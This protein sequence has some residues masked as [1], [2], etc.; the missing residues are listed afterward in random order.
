MKVSLRLTMSIILALT[1]A[2]LAQK[3]PK[4]A[5]GRANKGAGAAANRGAAGRSAF[6][7]SF[8]QIRWFDSNGN[9][10]IDEDEFKAGMGKMEKNAGKAMAVLKQAFD[11]DGDGK[12]SQA[13]LRKVREFVWALMG[14][15]PYDRNR[16]WVMSDEEWQGAWD[17]VGERCHQ[18][19]EFLLRRF[20][21]NG[22]EALGPD[23]VTAGKEQLA[24][25]GQRGTRPK[26]AKN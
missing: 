15:Q 13:E 3:P 8:M 24:K 20:D 7:G 23:E 19:N 4:A 10:L 16:D 6:P 2:V 21:K 18:Y 12:F 5:G 11:A 9:L 17:K 26:R 14:L 22:D 25:R 1:S